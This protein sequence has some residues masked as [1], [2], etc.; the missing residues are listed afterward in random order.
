MVLGPPA[1]GDSDRESVTVG[2]YGSPNHEEQIMKRITMLAA[3]GALFATPALGA[4]AA[5]AADDDGPSPATVRV[6][7]RGRH[8]GEAERGDDHRRH[9]C[10]GADHAPGHVRHSGEP[11]PAD[12]HGRHGDDDPAGHVRHSGEP[13]PGDDNGGDAELEVGDDH[14]GHGE[15]EPGDDHGGDSRSGGDSA[16][17][18]G[19]RSDDGG[20]HGGDD[21]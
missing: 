5:F 11:E 8:S 3:A 12:D 10:H 15:L 1:D 19:S 9:Q 6:T 4:W 14:G 2:P 16:G 20:H 7:D 17:D 13:E 18:S 21:D